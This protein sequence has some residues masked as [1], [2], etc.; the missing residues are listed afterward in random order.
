MGRT[1]FDDVVVQ[2]EKIYPAAWNLVGEKREREDNL[3]KKGKMVVS[4]ELLSR[5]EKET[6]KPSLKTWLVQKKTSQK[7]AR[8]RGQR[9][10]VGG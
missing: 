3:L 2:W 7:A 6:Q 10:T 9:S 1:L 4:L 5:S 8:K